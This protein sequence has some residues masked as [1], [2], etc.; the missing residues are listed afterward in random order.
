MGQTARVAL[1]RRAIDRTGL[2]PREWAV[3]VAWRNE[4]T[5]R[6]WL[7]GASPVP[8]VVAAALVKQEEELQKLAAQR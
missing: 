7:S 6:R 1:L 2:G 5:V 3:S 8:L 4:R